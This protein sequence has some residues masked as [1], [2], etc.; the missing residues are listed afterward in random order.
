MNLEE[1]INTMVQRYVITSAQKGA[2]YNKQL[3]KNIDKYCADNNAEL[4]ILPLNGKSVLDERLHKDLELRKIIDGDYTLNSNIKVKNHYISPQQINPLTGIERFAQGDKSFVFGSPKQVLKYV[5]NSYDVIPKAVLT[6]GAIT[7]PYYKDNRIGR[8]AK[9]D[10]EYGFVVVELED[11]NYFH[12]RQVKAL[13]NGNFTDV[14][15][16]YNNGR[17]YKPKAKALVVGD[18]HPYHTDPVHEKCTLDQIKYFGGGL[19]VFLHDTF[20]GLSISHHWEGHNILKEQY[21]KK[22]GL[23]LEKELITTA[24]AINRYANSTKGKVNIVASNHDEWLYRYLDSGR[25]VGD[26]GNSYLGALLYAA[27]VD[28]RNPLEFGLK[29]VNHLYPNV[30]FLERDKGFKM[31]GYELGNHG[32]LGANGG[33]ASP[34]STEIANAKSITGHGHSAF[35]IRD[36]YRVGTSTHLRLDYNKGYSNW[37]QTNAVLYADGS[38]QLLNTIAKGWK[39]ED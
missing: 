35:K 8:I 15:G 4:L 39:G 25:F 1:K 33:R 32:D 9:E 10:H 14:L 13:K 19:D 23:N 16:S 2:G 22:Q 11:K 31:F 34:R 24:D 3:L 36:T 7:K 21:H 20:N 17:R 5:A 37:T 6:T 12:L 28:N 27:S 30:V 26:A 18:L 38:V 29:Y